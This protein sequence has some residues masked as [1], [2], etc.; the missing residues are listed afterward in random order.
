MRDGSAL[1]F[2]TVNCYILSLVLCFASLIYDQFSVKVFVSICEHSNLLGSLE[3][4]FLFLR[5]SFIA[6]RNVYV[7]RFYI[8]APCG[9]RVKRSGDKEME[10]LHISAVSQKDIW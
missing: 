8:R 2:P 6:H 4:V 1:Y 10:I 3:Y 5:Q 9:S 7:P